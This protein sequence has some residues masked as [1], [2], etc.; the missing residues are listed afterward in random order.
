MQ[1]ECNLSHKF[2]L[3]LIYIFVFRDGP[4]S[5]SLFVPDVEFYLTKIYARKL[6]K[7]IPEIRERVAFH[8]VS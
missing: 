1:G 6:I 7:C 8:L 2:H 4:I 5:V 3:Y